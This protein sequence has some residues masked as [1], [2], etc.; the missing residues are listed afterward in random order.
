MQGD[1][2]KTSI[3][4]LLFLIFL[5]ILII[6]AVTVVTVRD[7]VDTSGTMVQKSDLRLSMIQEG[8]TWI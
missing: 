4:K 6:I 8:E 2:V 7:K 3:K 1:C 5:L